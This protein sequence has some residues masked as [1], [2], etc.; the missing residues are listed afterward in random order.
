M[1]LFPILYALSALIPAACATVPQDTRASTALPPGECAAFSGDRTLLGVTPEAARQGET[2][3]LRAWSPQGPAAP[4]VIPLDCLTGWAVNPAG[5]ATV[6]PDGTRLT[7]APDAPAGEILTVTATAPGGFAYMTTVLVGR[8]E[9]VLTGRWSEI[10]ARCPNGAPAQPLR[11]WSSPARAN[12]PSPSCPSRPTRTIGAEPGSRRTAAC[13]P[14]RLK[15]A[16]TCR[17][18]GR[19][20]ARRGSTIRGA[21]CWTASRW[22]S[23]PPLRALAAMCSGAPDP[24]RA[25]VAA[26]P[27]RTARSAGSRTPDWR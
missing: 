26:P 18:T 13:W 4:K 7:I 8:T 1:R 12:S 20:S 5:A 2:L 16:T 14:C 19:W 9:I 25:A 24:A 6:S 15:A 3:T 21:S 22:G 23:A 27:A 10:E 11:E 17:L